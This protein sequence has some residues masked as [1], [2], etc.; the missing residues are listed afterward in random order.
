MSASKEKQ[1]RD[2]LL[3]LGSGL[4]GAILLVLWMLHYYGP[5]GRYLAGNTLLSPE[6]I[7]QLKK[8]I[9]P[10]KKSKTSPIV[11]E[12]ITFSYYDDKAKQW[13]TQDVKGEEYAL[14]YDNIGSDKS[15]AEVDDEVIKQFLSTNVATLVLHV[16]TDLGR[17]AQRVE[18]ASVGDDYRIELLEPTPEGKWIYM[19]HPHIYQEAL[20]TFVQDGHE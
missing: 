4:L 6:V 15:L 13:K 18:F 11:F 19:H 10:A 8:G 17:L 1:V 9:A 2:L 20:N 3:V 12:G 14:F 7:G 5:T 16:K